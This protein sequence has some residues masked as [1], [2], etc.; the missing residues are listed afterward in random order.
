MERA[1][2]A[3]AGELGLSLRVAPPRA[4]VARE[5]RTLRRL[6]ARTAAR[7]IAPGSTVLVNAGDVSL[8]LADELQS[9]SG[10]TIITNSFDVLERLSGRPNL[11]VILTSG[12]YQAQHRCLVGPSL[13]A[14][15]ETLRV[16]VAF[17]AVDGVSA[18][19]GPSS[20][21]ERR[22]LAAQRF[23]NASRETIVLA[24]HSLVG[25][26]ANHRI[27]P[28]DAVDEIITDSGSLPA[29]RLAFASAGTR[30]TLADE[31]TQE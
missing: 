12:E 15:F 23:I 1:M 17:L 16:D 8:L 4:G 7:R 20:S 27:A 30:V 18:R 22:A 2:R 31:E 11:K 28:I 21:D 3:R 14:L 19:F 9:L 10:A 25:L 26:E 29:D 13:G 5:I 24:D 6:I